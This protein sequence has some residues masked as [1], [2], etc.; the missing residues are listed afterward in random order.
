MVAYSDDY[1]AARLVE[2]MVELLVQ[3]TVEWMETKGAE[4]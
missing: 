2:K 4:Q 1:M 3:K